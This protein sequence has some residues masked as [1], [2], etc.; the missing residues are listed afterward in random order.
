MHGVVDVRPRKQRLPPAPVPSEALGSER[1]S[2][3]LRY[4]YEN[5]QQELP[6]DRS[7]RIAMA[8]S[9]GHIGMPEHLAVALWCSF[10]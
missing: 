4:E 5:N 9:L 8:T 2:S 6:G 10:S 7:W 3:R 1:R